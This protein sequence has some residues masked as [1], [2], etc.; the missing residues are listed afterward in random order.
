MRNQGVRRNL[1]CIAPDTIRTRPP[2][3]RAAHQPRSGLLPAERAAAGCCLSHRGRQGPYL[4]VHLPNPADSVDVWVSPKGSPQF[5]LNSKLAKKQNGTTALLAM[6]GRNR[7]PLTAF[8]TFWTSAFSLPLTIDM[9][10]TVPVFDTQ[11]LARTT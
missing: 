2:K 10:S 8:T 7:H 9:L 4:C 6:S 5:A 11:I 3:R 1:R